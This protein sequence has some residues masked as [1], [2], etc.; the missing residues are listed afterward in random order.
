[1][2]GGSVTL[3]RWVLSF[4]GL[5][6]LP[7]IPGTWGTAG[8]VAAAVALA[9]FVPEAR[10]NW[11]LTCGVAAVAALVLTVW[12]TPSL[13]AATGGK[14]PQIIVMDEVAGYFATLLGSPDPD[15]ATL[16]TAFV[17]FRFLDIV[18]PWPA[19]ALEK[20]PSGW[21]VALDDIASG[22]YGAALLAGV[23][24]LTA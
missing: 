24:W 14:D 11:V 23:R 9:A 4:G 15:A 16:L 2:K 21:G 18:K 3:E 22:L 19:C 17:V 6:L 5:G 20:L 8:A 7:A 12:L 13:E 1:M 10:A